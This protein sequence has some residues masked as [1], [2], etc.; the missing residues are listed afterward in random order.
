VVPTISQSAPNSGIPTLD[1]LEVESQRVISATSIPLAISQFSPDAGRNS[2]LARSGKAEDVISSTPI[3]PATVNNN[4]ITLP[5]VV[6]TISMRELKKITRNFCK[7][8]LIGEGS[9]SKVFLGV[10][11]DGYT[12]AIKMLKP[13]EEIILE[14][15]ACPS[16]FTIPVKF[17]SLSVQQG[18]PSN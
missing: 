1:L 5:S 18:L 14:V 16:F 15:S 8:A 12:S 10:L 3:T 7:D 6:P 9:S 2:G 17:L 13:D 11:E 4:D